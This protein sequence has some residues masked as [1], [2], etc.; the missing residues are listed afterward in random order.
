M[1]KQCL[2]LR[3]SPDVVVEF[4]EGLVKRMKKFG[5]D[6]DVLTIFEDALTMCEAVKRAALKVEREADS[7]EKIAS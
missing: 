7:E 1:S 3:N 2:V 5:M 6:E 4:F